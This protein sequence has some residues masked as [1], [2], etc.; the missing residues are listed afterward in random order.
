M[1]D[2]LKQVRPE[3]ALFTTFTLS[4]N[5]FESYCLPLLKADGC[6]QIDL[7]VDLRE[8]CKL[9]AETTSAYAGNA[10]R[11]TTVAM[12]GS[13]IFHPKLAYLQSEDVDTLVV[14]SGN[15]THPGQGGNLEVIDAV[16][17]DEHPLVFEEFA[18]FVD[19]F[20]TRPGVSVE[21]VH[22]L[23]EYSVRAKHV[24]SLATPERRS[25]ERTVWFVHTL[26]DTAL[27]QFSTLVQQALPEAR[28][29]TLYSPYHTAS[30]KTVAALAKACETKSVRV[31]LNRDWNPQT[32]TYGFFAPFDVDAKLLPAKLS[33]V[34]PVA[35]RDFS[36]SHAKC[37]EV[38]SRSGCLVMTGSVNATWQSLCETRNA[39]V[40][41]VRKL[42]ASPFTWET[43]E[44]THFKACEYEREHAS[45]TLNSLQASWRDNVISGTIAPAIGE[46]TLRL[47]IIS[48]NKVEFF[49]ENVKLDVDGN[50]RVTASQTCNTDFALRLRATGK[51][52]DVTGW[53]NVERELACP[54]YDR[55]LSR[56]ASR[57]MSR[58][59]TPA[60]LRQIL[61]QFRRIL[62][63]ERTAAVAVSGDQAAFMT[64]SKPFTT[65]YD[66][67]R[68]SDQA[69]LGLSLHT[70]N[71]A[72]AAAFVTLRHPQKA[73][74][75][76][77]G[78]DVKPR[79]PGAGNPGKGKGRKRRNSATDPWAEM[80]K[81]LPSV[82]A[83][84]A[85]GVW[86]PALVALSAKKMLGT[87]LECL[88]GLDER[89]EKR[90]LVAQTAL[91]WLNTYCRF[92]Y[93]PENRERLVAPF[94]AMAACI[95]TFSRDAQATIPR[96]KQALERAACRPLI[97]EEWLYTVD[98]ALQTKV[99]ETLD[100]GERNRVLEASLMLGE[101]PSQNDRLC[102]MIVAELVGES[103]PP[104]R[105]TDPYFSVQKRLRELR[106][107]HQ[108]TQRERHIFGVIG[109]DV[110]LV[111]PDTSC[112]ACNQSLGA[113]TASNL[114]LYGAA[115]HQPD[116]D[117]PVFAGLPREVLAA[118]NLPSFFYRYHKV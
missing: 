33:Y 24:A 55:D 26:E 103:T 12:N 118:T 8:G 45:E 106:K 13:G 6:N 1:T 114:A 105:E 89:V 59:A 74:S 112:P 11:I 79:E 97:A 44:A 39:E 32:N 37:F 117:K 9:G 46:K 58:E 88:E 111:T 83:E 78:D 115:I 96:L 108:R 94:A 93:S 50:F 102:Q 4:L 28:Q 90:D 85:S 29:L 47:E 53:L 98:D 91:Q 101:A 70:A 16:T 77:P 75:G 71:Q 23:R 57:I 80:L 19:V 81:T 18:R 48:R 66:A 2:L 5:W 52:V 100:E 42:D 20:L 21:T 107:H 49:V 56:T 35:G 30:G 36:F 68:P 43:A 41:L 40:A 110:P 63:R 95:L 34:T 67:W 38:T 14:G 61:D 17:S 10:F 86:M 113:T 82:L 3:R 99:Y 15:L 7:L 116:C 76:I 62:R 51:G 104:G 92:D 69:R 64:S 60:D 73:P 84:N 27:Q 22:V 65:R 72:L 25:A 54:P 109:P 31:G 87:A